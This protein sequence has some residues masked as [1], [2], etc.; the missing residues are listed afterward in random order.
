LKKFFAL[1]LAAIYANVVYAQNS[2]GIDESIIAAAN[3]LKERI[4]ANMTVAVYD[5]SSDSRNL[6]DYIIDELTIALANTGMDVYDRKYSSTVNREITRGT[7]DAV[8]P[9]TAQNYGRD[10][11]A[12]TVIL[13][14][15]T[16]FRGNEYRFRVQAIVTETKRI[17][18]ATTFNVKQDEQLSSLLGIKSAYR[19]TSSQKLNAGFKNLAFGW[20]SFEMGDPLGGGINIGLE[21]VSLVSLFIGIQP[22]LSPDGGS[23]FWSDSKVWN[24]NNLDF[25]LD[26]WQESYAKQQES[27]AKQDQELRNLHTTL[28]VVGA[29]GLVGAWT[30]GFVRPYLY[31]KPAAQKVASVI[32]HLK[33]G[34]VP[35]SNGTTKVNFILNY[36]F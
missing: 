1:L 22:L 28:A 36:R 9:D 18:A 24:D 31:D 34:V 17:Q 35:A 11:G 21:L 15:F 16:N 30:W 33:I 4:P 13:G 3:F 27:I 23:V 29:V 5:F 32:D 10:V 6:S 7:T 2:A 19:F 26:G 12:Q 8:D 25:Y 20:G 14:S